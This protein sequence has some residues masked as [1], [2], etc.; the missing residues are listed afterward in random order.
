MSES[1][2]AR[3]DE[4]DI[5]SLLA[6]L[7][8]FQELTAAQIGR[9]ASE[10]AL[11]RLAKGEVL[12]HQGDEAHGFFVM[13]GGQIK[14]AFSS[15]QGNEKV[16]EIVGPRQSFGEAVMFMGRPYPVFA[17]A[18]ADTV[19]LQ[20]AKRTVFDLLATDMTFA[21][22]MLAGLSRRLHSLVGDVEAYSLRSGTQRLIGYL[23]QQHAEQARTG[24][25]SSLSLPISKQVLASRL[26]LTPESLSRVLHELSLAKL[27]SVQGRQ[28]TIH[29]LQRLRE[30]DL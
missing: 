2:L 19:L 25:E 27:I 9:V 16:V 13:V 30:F 17:Q 28:V 5:A 26:N 20:I 3:A 11:R 21:R 10:T 22:S 1:S 18:L 23:L 24:D 8:L 7:P 4:P 12:F 29:E 14:L 15:V 6:R